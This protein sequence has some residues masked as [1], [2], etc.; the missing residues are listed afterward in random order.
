[1]INARLYGKLEVRG[2]ALAVDYYHHLIKLPVAPQNK[3]VVA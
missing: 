2:T 1:L 3:V